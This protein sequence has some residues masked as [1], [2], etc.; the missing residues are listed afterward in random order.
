MDRKSAEARLEERP[1]TWSVLVKEEEREQEKGRE[2][3]SGTKEW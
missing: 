1:Q 2:G 3:Q